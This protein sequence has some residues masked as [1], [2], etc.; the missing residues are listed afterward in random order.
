MSNLASERPR[1]T[2][3]LGATGLKA[4][5]SSL[6]KTVPKGASA[7]KLKAKVRRQRLIEMELASRGAPEFVE[8]VRGVAFLNIN[9]NAIGTNHGQDEINRK[10]VE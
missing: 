2:L 3:K 1:K 10:H 5:L 9:Q 4:A 8:R 6:D 7:A